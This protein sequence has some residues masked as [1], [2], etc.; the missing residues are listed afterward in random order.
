MFQGLGLLLLSGLE[1]M[2]EKQKKILYF[3]LVGGTLVFSGSIFI[4][5][6]K[7]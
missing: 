6:F 7:S 1:F 2:T 3:L 4:L 5:S